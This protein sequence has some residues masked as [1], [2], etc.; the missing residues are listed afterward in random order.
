MVYGMRLCVILKLKIAFTYKCMLFYA[1]VIVCLDYADYPC[2][3]SSD[4]FVLNFSFL[5]TV[6]VSFCC[7]VNVMVALRK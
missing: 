5:V 6:F 3:S 2:C 7:A 1:Y 4:R